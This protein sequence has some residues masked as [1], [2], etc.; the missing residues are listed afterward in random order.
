MN[1]ALAKHDLYFNAFFN[2]IDTIDLRDPDPA[3]V[4]KLIVYGVKAVNTKQ[5]PS[6]INREETTANFQFADLI[7]GLMGLLKPEEFVNLF[8][9]AKEY[10]GNKYQTKDYF[11]TRN[12]IGFLPDEPIGDVDKVMEFL[13]EYHN[14]EIRMFLVNTI[15]YASDLRQLQGQPGITEEWCTK[16]GIKTFTMHTCQ[17]GKQ[18]MVDNETGK[19]IKVKKK[20]P[21]YLKLVKE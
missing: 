5:K 7:Q 14:R 19:S 9:I 21:N 10:D 11:Y 18:F 3:V 13:W 8:P 15:S 12:Y 2:A 17:N 16:N 20:M 6:V 4:K 1:Q